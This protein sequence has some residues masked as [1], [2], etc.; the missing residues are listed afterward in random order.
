MDIEIDIE[1][2][3]CGLYF[4]DNFREMPHGRVLKCPFCRSTALGLKGQT[5]IERHRDAFE[6]E[7]SPEGRL[8]LERKSK[9]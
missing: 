4:R 3:G 8:S 5:L 7:R 1:C 2:H 6:F 9:L